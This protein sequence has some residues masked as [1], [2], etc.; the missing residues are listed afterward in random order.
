MGGAGG[1]WAVDVLGVPLYDSS[2]PAR[3]RKFLEKSGGDGVEPE[4][5]VRRPVLRGA[6]AGS[7]RVG[8]LSPVST[9]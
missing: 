7:G 9:I 1:A 6:A 8:T 3:F 5:T 2:A 4:G